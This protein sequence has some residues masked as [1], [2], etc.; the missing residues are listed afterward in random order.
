MKKIYFL[1]FLLCASFSS[2]MAQMQRIESGGV[3]FELES[4]NGM[5]AYVCQDDAHKSLTEVT[6]PSTVEYDGQTYTV[7][8][9]AGYA[10]SDCKSLTKVTLPNTITNIGTEAFVRCESLDSISI[11][12]SVARIEN[13]AFHDCSSLKSVVLPTSMEY[14]GHGAFYGCTSLPSITI[15]AGLTY[16]DSYTF[17]YCN[18]LNNV[19]I[20]SNITSIG[21]EAF[22]H[23]SSLKSISLPDGLT[24]IEGWSFYDC[25]S[26]LSIT[27]PSSVTYLE[28]YVFY[29]CN[30]LDS[31]TISTNVKTIDKYAFNST[32]I[33][34]VAI[35]AGSI[36]ELVES[37]LKLLLFERGISWGTGPDGSIMTRFHIFVNGVEQKG[38]LVIPDGVTR[39]NKHALSYCTELNSVEVPNSVNSI[40]EYAFR[41]LSFVNINATTPPTITSTNIIDEDAFIVLPD[42]A[43]LAT[44]QAHPVW[45]EFGT[46]LISK[47]A[48][49]MRE[50]TV[51]ASNSL[52]SLHKTIGEENLLNTIKLK[53]HGTINSYDIMLI[54]NKMLNLRY[55][56]L[57]DAEVRACSYEYYSGYCTHDNILEDHS[58]SDLNLQV[59]HLPKNLTEIRNC[60]NS[61]Q[62]LDT[63]YF[64]P[65]LTIIGDNTFQDCRNLRYVKLD[66]GVTRIGSNAFRETHNLKYINLPNSLEY[67]GYEAFYN[68]GLPSITFPAN[69]SYIEGNAFHYGQLQHIT[70]APNC[71]LQQINSGTFQYQYNLQSIDWENTNILSKR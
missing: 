65:G 28:G 16:I 32:S 30:R 37:D 67:I 4:W 46:R 53:V 45:S 38:D 63:V 15:P 11:P 25:D 2:V 27:L 20:P 35:H 54:R 21:Y 13:D 26:L 14:L 1:V 8:R 59:V 31:L 55:L 42:A 43:T 52:S 19:N 58:F 62:K 22:S 61:C 47:D 24:K 64:Q 49:Q 17:S 60:F 57:S 34:Y 41:G 51:T 29:H 44:Y 7:D 50:V 39:I 40:G 18:A 23:C 9:I 71:K 70:F 56:D 68:S 10:F 3:Y 69:L 6:I 12:N 36:K 5:T 48:M 33:D 66:E